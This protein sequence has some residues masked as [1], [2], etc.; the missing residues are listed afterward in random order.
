MYL[1]FFLI[2][3]RAILNKRVLKRGTSYSSSELIEDLIDATAH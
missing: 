1:I 2:K 3:L